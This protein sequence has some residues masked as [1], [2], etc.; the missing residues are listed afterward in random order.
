SKTNR[1]GKLP[2]W[3]LAITI[4]VA[5]SREF[6]VITINYLTINSSSQINIKGS[7]R[8]WEDRQERFTDKD[9][10]KAITTTAQNYE[11]GFHF[12]PDP[13]PEID[14]SIKKRLAEAKYIDVFQMKSEVSGMYLLPMSK[15]GHFKFS[16]VFGA[17]S[18]GGKYFKGELTGIMDF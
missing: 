17:K 13:G 4:G 7:S 15:D 6:G 5:V 3:I 16:L 8:Y 12:M 2:L 11:I 10:K 18:T 1:W 9:S 14:A